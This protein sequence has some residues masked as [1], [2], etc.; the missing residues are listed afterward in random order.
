MVFFGSDFGITPKK[1]FYFIN[2]CKFDPI[3]KSL[4]I[5]FGPIYYMHN[6]PFIWIIIWNN[7]RFI[8]IRT[9]DYQFSPVVREVTSQLWTVVLRGIWNNLEMNKKMGGIKSADLC[10]FRPEI[11]FPHKKLDFWAFF[12]FLDF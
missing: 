6:H 7:S 5:W 4:V 12:H 3:K 10:T 8:F 2:I 9:K 11:H 1:Q